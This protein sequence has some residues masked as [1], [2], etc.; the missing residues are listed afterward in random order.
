MPNRP[1][2]LIVTEE[3]GSL[4]SVI[5]KNLVSNL[6]YAANV[7]FEHEPAKAVSYLLSGAFSVALIVCPTIY[8]STMKPNRSLRDYV[9]DFA[10]HQGGT[11]LFS[12]TFSSCVRPLDFDMYFES[13]WQLP[14]RI[15][16]CH[17]TTFALNPEFSLDE[18]DHDM[19]PTELQTTG[20]ESAYSQRA[21]HVRGAARNTMLYVPTEDS[22]LESLFFH[23]GRIHDLT[24]SPTVFQTWGKGHVGFFGDVTSEIGTTKT[25]LVLCGLTRGTRQP[26]VISGESIPDAGEWYCAGCGKQKSSKAGIE[27]AAF[28]RCGRCL[29]LHYCS[30]TCNA[31]HWSRRH[32]K[33][34][35]YM[36]N[37]D[38]EVDME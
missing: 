15:A 10:E 14:W 3:H 6:N 33:E 30:K 32:W 8:F 12:G 16:S 7:M 23:L 22:R 21:V 36:K 2:I 5:W 18:N 29:I 19:L 1:Q 26:S 27:E 28:K 34:C 20:L 24:L 4:F 38:D 37:E 35:D 13:E 17:R 25:I 11:V 9:R 31:A